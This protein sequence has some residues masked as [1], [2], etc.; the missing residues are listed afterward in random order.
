MLK[1]SRA[2]EKPSLRVTAGEYSREQMEGYSLLQV[3]SH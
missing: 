3:E 1:Q 2:V